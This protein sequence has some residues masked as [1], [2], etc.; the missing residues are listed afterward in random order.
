MVSGGAALAFDLGVDAYVTPAFRATASLAMTWRISGPV[1]CAG[2]ATTGGY[3]SPAAYSDANTIATAL[4]LG[5][6]FGAGSRDPDRRAARR[7]P[8]PRR[9]ISSIV[10]SM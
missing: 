1:A 5:A 7:Y 8:P 6:T 2:E 10:D 9:S 4:R 3:E